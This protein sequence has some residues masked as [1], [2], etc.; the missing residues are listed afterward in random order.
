MNFSISF[1]GDTQAS[2]FSFYVNILYPIADLKKAPVTMIKR[3][4]HNSLSGIDY[5][6][7][8]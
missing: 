2:F 8:Y 1:N 5:V 3:L 6:I 7:E 4:R